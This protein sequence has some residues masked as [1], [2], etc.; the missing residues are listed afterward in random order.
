MIITAIGK[1]QAREG[2]EFIYTGPQQQ[3]RECKYKNVCITLE[4][5]NMYRVSKVRNVEHPCPIHFSGIKV[6]EVEKINKGFIVKGLL[7]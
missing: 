3:C 7:L 6:I 2:F 5:G 1:L 4:R